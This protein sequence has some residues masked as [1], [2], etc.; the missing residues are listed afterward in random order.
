MRLVPVRFGYD[1]A[2]LVERVELVQLELL[3]G[4]DEAH[5]RTEQ[6]R[7]QDNLRDLSGASRWRLT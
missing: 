1:A 4:F 6:A 7:E 2:D 5:L 3:E